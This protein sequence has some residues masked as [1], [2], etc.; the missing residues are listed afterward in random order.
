MLKKTSTLRTLDPFLDSDGVMRVGGRHRYRSHS[1]TLSSYQ[2]Q[3][4]LLHWLSATR[5]KKH[6]IAEEDVK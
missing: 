1:K 5:T 4:T 3:A 2:S 6:T